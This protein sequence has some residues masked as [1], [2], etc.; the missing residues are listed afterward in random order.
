MVHRGLTSKVFVITG[1]ASGIGL[2]TVRRLVGEGS[3]VAVVDR[4]AQALQQVVGEFDQS[5]V[6]GIC[7][8]VADPSDVERYFQAT[9]ERFDRVDGLYNNAGTTGKN[10]E[11]V[12]LPLEAFEHVLRV[13]VVGTLLGMQRMLQLSK[14]RGTPGVVLNTASGLAVR[15]AVQQGAYAASKAAVISLTRTAA[16]EAA[17]LGVRVNVIVP[18]PTATPMLMANPAEMIERFEQLMPFKRFGEPDEVA[19]TAAWLLSDE[20]SFCTGAVFVVDGGQGA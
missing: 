2:A 12:D 15:A 9:L 20:S 16:L 10:S 4:S 13:N 14:E 8:D 7:A 19:A 6:I 5:Q 1:G 3:R 17:S 11:L 18:G